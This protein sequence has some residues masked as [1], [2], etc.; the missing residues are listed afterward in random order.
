MTWRAVVSRPGV[1]GKDYD[2]RFQVVRGLTLAFAAG[3]YTRPIFG[4]S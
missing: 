3:A 1:W 2:T 4:S